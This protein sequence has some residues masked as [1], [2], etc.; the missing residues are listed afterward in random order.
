MSH[1]SIWW[2]EKN[3]AKL[4]EPQ[5]QVLDFDA[6]TLVVITCAFSGSRGKASCSAQSQSE[7][8]RQARPIFSPTLRFSHLIVRPTCLSLSISE[9]PQL[10]SGFPEQ[11][12][13]GWRATVS[14][15]LDGEELKSVL[16]QLL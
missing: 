8:E 4:N 1:I 16:L 13:Q 15:A 10:Q 6:S 5:G 3:M 11:G 7:N 9:E 14:V 2:C 12:N